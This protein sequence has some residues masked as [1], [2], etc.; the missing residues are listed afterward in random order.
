MRNVVIFL[1]LG[2]SNFIAQ[3]HSDNSSTS[4]DNS[5]RVG[6]LS[7]AVARDARVVPDV[8]VPDVA[9]A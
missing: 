8:F 1:S 4:D 5:R 9:D 2:S 3:T 7:L 6:D